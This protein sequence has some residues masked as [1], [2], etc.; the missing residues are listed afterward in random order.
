MSFT[1]IISR[2]FGVIANI[3]FFPPI[4]HFINKQYIRIFKIDLRE[5]QPYYYYKSLNELFTRG[6]R[7]NREFDKSDEIFISPIDGK[8]MQTGKVENDKAL[9]IKGFSYSVERLVGENVDSTLRYANLYLS[10]SNYHRY[11]APC[12]MWV[13]SI[14]HFNGALLP[15]HMKS[16]RKNRNL[17][18]RNE[19]VVLKA[20][21]KFGNILYFVAVGALNVGGIIFYIEP[22]IQ[23]KHSSY[24]KSFHYKNPKFIKKGEEI[25]MFKMGSTIVLLASQV[26]ILKSDCDISFGE[27]LFKHIEQKDI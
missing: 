25:G 27:S 1:K 15:V 5:F 3:K 20:R 4:Q 7:V 17:F 24:K 9:Q 23:N 13:E 26:E 12:D 10:P 21:D 16:L 6:L 19:R 18:V 11:H 8:V 22:R 14:S 2:C